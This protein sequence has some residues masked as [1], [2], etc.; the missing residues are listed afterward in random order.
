LDSTSRSDKKGAAN[1]LI[2]DQL[3]LIA[4]GYGVVGLHLAT[5]LVRVYPGRI[6]V[7]GRSIERAREA[8]QGLG[9][10]ASARAIDVNDAVSVERALEGV[11]VVVSCVEQTAPA[12]LLTAAA[13]RGL[14]YTDLTASSIWRRALAL[15]AQAEA[16]GARIVLGAGL[17]PGISSAMA[18]AAADQ[19]G[20]LDAIHTALLL[21]AG[22]AFGPDSLT[23][24]LR[25]FAAPL[26]V[27]ESGR[28][29][30]VACFSEGRPVD[31][32]AP[33]G[34]RTAWRAPFADQ[35][36]FPRSLGVATATTRLALDPPWVGRVVS[37]ALQAGARRLLGREG[38]RSFVRRLVLAVHTRHES[39]DCWAL[40]VDAVGRRGTA[41]YS[42]GGRGQAEAAAI[43]ASVLARMLCDGAIEKPGV[44]FAEELVNPE[45]FFA[46]LH[47]AGLDV[48][49][50]VTT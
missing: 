4:G 46:E 19:L 40:V 20:S 22:D 15:R 29:R 8:A 18:R 34:Q 11:G 38:F 42:L 25:E 7:A 24:L 12:I 5:H 2:V 30:S 36:F 45:R 23:Y 21:N 37:A 31:F 26:V 50:E 43:A 48:S 6:A 33:I 41:R 17:V 9:G 14:A 1:R 47:E 35:Y 39:S 16:T 13:A 28:E 3:I 10:G 49:R 32:P 44:S 27:T